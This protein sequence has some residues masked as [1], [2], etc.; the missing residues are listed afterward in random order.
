MDWTNEAP[1]LWIKD[2]PTPVLPPVSSFS[3]LI[4]YYR[5]WEN[6]LASVLE[7]TTDL[8]ILNPHASNYRTFSESHLDVVV[9]FVVVEFWLSL[10]VLRVSSW[11]FTQ[12]FCPAPS[13]GTRG[14]RGWIGV[15]CVQGLICFAISLTLS[16]IIKC[17]NFIAAVWRTLCFIC[18]SGPTLMPE[19]LRELAFPCVQL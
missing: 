11:I 2:H 14:A 6:Q 8:T 16:W 12:R 13:A 15:G 19:P 4:L 10:A 5:C 3:I 18:A 7:R 9:V 17:S 1:A